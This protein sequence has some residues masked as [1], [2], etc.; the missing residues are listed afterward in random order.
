MH[1]SLSKKEFS[2][3][4]LQNNICWHWDLCQGFFKFTL[5]P[6]VWK[7]PFAWGGSQDLDKK[8]MEP[9]ETSDK[10]WKYHKSQLT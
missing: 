5:I 9:E 7:S 10:N 8:K 6:Q 2:T 1:F 3:P 4:D